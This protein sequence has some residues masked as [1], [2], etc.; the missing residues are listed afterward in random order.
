MGK[1][2]GEEEGKEQ[3]GESSDDLD[4]EVSMEVGSTFAKKPPPM[5]LLQTTLA[6]SFSKISEKSAENREN[7]SPCSTTKS[8]GS[9][10]FNF[11]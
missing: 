8:F 1:G 4:R 10:K 3:K 2:E 9:K 6:N 5:P 7:V 11:K